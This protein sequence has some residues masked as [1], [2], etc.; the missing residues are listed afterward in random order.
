MRTGTLHLQSS[1]A[2]TIIEVLE[3][4]VDMAST[5]V[6]VIRELPEGFFDQAKLTGHASADVVY[7][8]ATRAQAMIRAQT[9]AR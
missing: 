7:A 8:T 9:W 5:A 3:A 6:V 1:F 2:S 4:L